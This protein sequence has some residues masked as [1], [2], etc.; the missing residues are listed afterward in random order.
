MATKKKVFRGGIEINGALGNGGADPILTRNESSKEVGKIPSITPGLTPVLTDGY[1]YIGDTTNTAIARLMIGDVSL[2]NLGLATINDGVIINSKISASA[3]IAYSKLNLTGSILN[4]DIHTSAAIARTKLAS[5]SNY[6]VIV[7]SSSGVMTEAGAI[8]GSR[9]LLS[10]SNGLPTFADTA[11]YPSL[12]E[13]SYVKGLTSAAQPQLGNRLSFSSAITPVTGDIIQY[14]GGVWTRLA[15]G[16]SGQYL[17]SNGTNVQ[18]VSVPN[19]LPVGGS[20]GQ[21]LNKIDGT[22]F[23]TQWSTLSTTSLTGVT[24]VANDVNILSGASAAGIS[25]TEFLFINGVNSNIQAQFDA[26]TLRSPSLPLGYLWIGQSGG[27]ATTLAPGTSSQVLTISGGVPVWST[28]L[29]SGHTIT[30]GSFTPYTQRTNLAF[31][32]GLTITDDPGNNATIITG[33]A[34][35]P[36]ADNTA[37]VKNNSD[38]TKLAIF[39][40][41]SISTG[42]TRTY[43]LPNADGTL[44]LTSDITGNFWKT[45]GTSTL[46]S[47]TDIIFSGYGLNFTG[48]GTSN[49]GIVIDD[50]AGLVV[51]QTVN[52]SSISNEWA[53]GAGN[54][55]SIINNIGTGVEISGQAT[56]DP[57]ASYLSLWNNAV[58]TDGKTVKT[59]IQYGA[60]GYETTDLTLITRGYALGAKTYT[61][62]QTLRDD[63]FILQDN[64]DLTKQA[65]FQLSG[66]TTGN[67]RT[68]TV[69]DASGTIA[70]AATTLSGYGITDAWNLGIGGTYTAANTLAMA[71]FNLNLLNGN[72]LSG[73]TGATI[74]DSTRLDVRGTGTGSGFAGRFA[75]SANNA[76]F[77]IRDDGFL[78]VGTSAALGFVA[79]TD[80]LSFTNSGSSLLFYNANNPG[81]TESFFHFVGNSGAAPASGNRAMFGL[82]STAWGWTV[83]SG[84]AA[85]HVWKVNN[86]INTTGSYVGEFNNYLYNPN[87][88]SSV[89]LT[90]YSFRTTAGSVKFV[91]DARSN[92]QGWIPAFESTGGAHTGMTASTA[93]PNE[94][95]GSVTQRK[96]I[97]SSEPLL[98]VQQQVERLQIYLMLTLKIL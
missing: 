78:Q 94:V 23:N 97:E 63:Y 8:T 55:G 85:G 83:S 24:S 58:Y 28:P 36:F 86:T 16:T 53:D 59:G 30:N 48:N 34:S 79:T 51:Q 6:R 50:G 92:S 93:F 42:T 75:S 43:I 81:A 84:T 37:L 60:S 66:I 4:A 47:G 89:G 15:V 29:A 18:W 67:T 25:P 35:N 14:T 20:A 64:G 40:A 95:F 13:L 98:I 62:L 9:I 76:L 74:T 65:N 27:N 41:A 57:A 49:Y 82:L 44:A 19:G 32:S 3:A 26:I 45:A 39:S 22:D 1:I 11:T 54:L 61:G 69:P 77:R 56:A 21:Y 68:L 73:P 12:T 2:T 88:T 87:L 33:N 46:T 5:G 70:L 90:H 17:S 31:G 71:G 52:T 10:D 7:N 91:Q 96:K 72:I 38:N 80:G